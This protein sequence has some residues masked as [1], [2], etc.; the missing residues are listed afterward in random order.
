MP[1]GH[2]WL[3][4]WPQAPRAEVRDVESLTADTMAALRRIS[5]DASDPDVQAVLPI[6]AE[7]PEARC[8]DG[9]LRWARDTAPCET[10]QETGR[11]LDAYSVAERITDWADTRQPRW[12]DMFYELVRSAVATDD[13]EVRALE[14]CRAAAVVRRE[15]GL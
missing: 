7:C 13:L 9:L 12:R 10:C 2:E 8:D 15:I 11:A 1:E 3:L 4:V 14:Y 5:L 6:L